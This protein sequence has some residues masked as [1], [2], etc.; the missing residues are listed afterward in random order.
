M[1]TDHAVLSPLVG[2]M[3]C[4]GK[5]AAGFLVRAEV[6]CPR[7]KAVVAL[8]ARTGLGEARVTCGQCANSFLSEDGSRLAVTTTPIPGLALNGGN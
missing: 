5:G 6:G 7:C 3:S 4:A 1:S 8:P 2:A